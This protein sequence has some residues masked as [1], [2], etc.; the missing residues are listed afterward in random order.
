M[1]GALQLLERR[2][3][4]DRFDEEVAATTETERYLGELVEAEHSFAV[5]G[6][7][8]TLVDQLLQ[9]QAYLVVKGWEHGVGRQAAGGGCWEVCVREREKERENK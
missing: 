2:G 7:V 5:G 6:A 4:S 9:L 1:K 3:Y 8:A